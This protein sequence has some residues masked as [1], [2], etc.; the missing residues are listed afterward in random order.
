M[1][2]NRPYGSEGGEGKS[3]PDPYRGV[4]AVSHTLAAPPTPARRPHGSPERDGAFG[5]G[6]GLPR[7]GLTLRE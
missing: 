7:I 2:E 5:T 1:R 6:P 4:I 3:L